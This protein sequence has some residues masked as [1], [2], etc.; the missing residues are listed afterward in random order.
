MQKTYRCQHKKGKKQ[1]TFSYQK[2]EG[3]RSVGEPCLKNYVKKEGLLKTINKGKV[4]KTML[5][6]FKKQ[7]K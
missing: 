6:V 1:F 5:S 7:W 2:E 4:I 3:G